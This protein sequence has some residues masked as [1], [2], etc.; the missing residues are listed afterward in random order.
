MARAAI[1]GIG[2]DVPSECVTNAELER[3]LGAPLHDWLVE[4]AGIER[5]H[6][7][8]RVLT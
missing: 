3:R 5:R 2:H 6:I 4:N 8:A 7:I 1:A